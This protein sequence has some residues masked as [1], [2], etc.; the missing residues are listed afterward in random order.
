MVLAAISQCVRVL[1]FVPM[2]LLA[3]AV[4]AMEAVKGALKSQIEPIDF[5]L[6]RWVLQHVAPSLHN[7]AYFILNALE[8]I[9]NRQDPRVDMVM[10]FAA[11]E[12]RAHRRFIDAALSY[13]PRAVLHASDE[14]RCDQEFLLNAIARDFVVFGYAVSYT[15][16]TLP[17]KA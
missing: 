7:D 8:A 9:N 15:H 17:T 13:T 6:F 12:L 3:D 2:E 1:E 4:V 5:E 14:L 16:L 11:E 10:S